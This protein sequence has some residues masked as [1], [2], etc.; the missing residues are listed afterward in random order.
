MNKKREVGW[1]WGWGWGGAY[2]GF[3]ALVGSLVEVGEEAEEEY[4]MTTD[5]PNK[6]L[7]IVAVDKEQLEGVHHN[8]DELDLHINDDTSLSTDNSNSEHIKSIRNSIKKSG[9]HFNFIVI[10]NCCQESIK[11]RSNLSENWIW[12]K[13]DRENAIKTIKSDLIWILRRCNQSEIE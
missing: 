8:G 3:V 9:I 1:G 13:N 6:R 12:M 10:A 4:S 5:P 11:N 7:G 2:A